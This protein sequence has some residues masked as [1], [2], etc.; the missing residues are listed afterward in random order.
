MT[1]PH[2]SRSLATALR[3]VADALERDAEAAETSVRARPVAGSEPLE[4]D[5]VRDVVAKLPTLATVS[6]TADA[7]RMSRRTVSRHL[8][9]G[10]LNAVRTGVG[11][12]SSRVLISRAEIARFLRRLHDEP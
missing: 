9:R 6:E 1:S 11:G 4:A 2:L 10:R 8:A 7:L 3:A 12:G 5:W